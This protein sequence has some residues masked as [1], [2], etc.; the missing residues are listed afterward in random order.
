MNN[1]QYQLIQILQVISQTHH[2]WRVLHQRWFWPQHPAWT[3]IKK[4][5]ANSWNWPRFNPGPHFWIGQELKVRNW[6]LWSRNFLI[7]CLMLRKIRDKDWEVILAF[8]NLVS[9]STVWKFQDMSV[10][11]IFHEINI[12]ECSSCKTALFS[13]SRGTE[14]CTF[15]KFQLSKSAKNKK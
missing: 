8:R 3:Q 6:W 11:Q 7:R 15:G 14:F 9:F 1:P 10:I 4:L 13:N 12:E 2:Q 5:W